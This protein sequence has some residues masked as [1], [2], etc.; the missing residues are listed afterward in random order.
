MDKYKGFVMSLNINDPSINNTHTIPS[1]PFLKKG[2][3]K[4]QINKTGQAAIT[5][6]N[7]NAVSKVK[8]HSNRKI[9][10]LSKNQTPSEAST[11]YDKELVKVHAYKRIQIFYIVALAY[12]GILVSSASKKRKLNQLDPES[13]P[14]NNPSKFRK[15]APLPDLNIDI[16]GA[17]AQV[18]KGKKTPQG[19]FH[20]AHSFLAPGLVD[21]VH[22][23]MMHKISQDQI[24]TPKK[25]GFLEHKGFGKK[26]IL[27]LEAANGSLKKIKEIFNKKFKNY[28]NFLEDTDLMPLMNTTHQLPMAVNLQCDKSLENFARPKLIGILKKLITGFL[29]AKKAT[30]LLLRIIKTHFRT[31][32]PLIN[33]RINFLETYQIKLKKIFSNKFVFSEKNLKQAVTKFYFLLN[34]IE[35]KHSGVTNIRLGANRAFVRE[36]KNL[37]SNTQSNLSKIKKH[38][39]KTIY[40]NL[41]REI[42]LQIRKMQSLLEYNALELKGSQLPD[43]NKISGKYDAITKVHHPLSPNSKQAEQLFLLKASPEV[44]KTLFI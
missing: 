1:M 6:V 18:G 22:E 39:K 37:S 24:V 27:A 38:L 43:F 12:E 20:A 25:K 10:S 23:I 19:T 4:N 41:S 11:Q 31:V 9:I 16:Q 30:K 7:S 36:L 44:K 13:N 42:D 21:N 26:D 15:I 29:D 14:T 40:Q 32:I 5:T 3:T 35:K 2:A 8:K 33:N 17:R 34:K 28:K